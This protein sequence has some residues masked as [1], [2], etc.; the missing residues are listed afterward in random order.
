MASY[1]DEQHLI[2][3]QEQWKCRTLCKRFFEFLNTILKTILL[4]KTLESW[5]KSWNLEKS[6]YMQ[7]QI[8]PWNPTKAKGPTHGCPHGGPP[9]HRQPVKGDESIYSQ[10]ELFLLHPTKLTCANVPELFKQCWWAPVSPGMQI[11]A[12]CLSKNCHQGSQWI[13]RLDMWKPCRKVLGQRL[14][15]AH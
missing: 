10:F 13:W 5:K 1:L 7:Y 2:L 14:T 8:H 6:Y 11:G 9:W 12:L 3:K 4:K 15:G